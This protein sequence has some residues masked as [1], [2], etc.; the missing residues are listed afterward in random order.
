MQNVGCLP[1][2]S[3]MACPASLFGPPR[4][5]ALCNT[6]G[7]AGGALEVD[8]AC[9]SSGS[10]SSTSVFSPVYGE[11]SSIQSNDVND[12]VG[13]EQPGLLLQPAAAE[14]NRCP[15][16][17]ITASTWGEREVLRGRWRGLDHTCPVPGAA[18]MDI[19]FQLQSQPPLALPTGAQK[20]GCL[21]VGA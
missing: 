19:V 3:P 7:T 11:E 8:G 1:G 4:P 13:R 9:G 14:T 6:P 12:V 21:G 10:L 5:S 18:C 15:S 2:C 17:T 20:V 16:G